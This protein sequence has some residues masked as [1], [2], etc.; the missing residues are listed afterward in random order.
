[1]KRTVFVMLLVTQF[2]VGFAIGRW[3]D[4]SLARLGNVRQ[5]RVTAYCPCTKCCGSWADGVTASGHKIAPGDAFVAAPKSIAFGT[6]MIV[7]GYANGRPVPV[8]DR[9]GAI[10][11]G[12][13]D[14][15]FPSHQAA[16]AW[17]VRQVDVTILGRP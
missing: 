13:L 1:M 3:G 16:L 6:M 5:F 9:G 11:E 2:A 14:V 12:R 8:F 10:K 7:P 15:F 4:E 17:G